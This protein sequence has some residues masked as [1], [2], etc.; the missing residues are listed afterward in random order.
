MYKKV[1]N[2][3]A[4]LMV[5]AMAISLCA[6]A[7][8]VEENSV[9]SEQNILETVD[10]NH[11][12]IRTFEREPSSP[13]INSIGNTMT[14]NDILLAL[15]MEQDF[16]DKLSDEDLE[17]YATSP[18]MVATISYAKIDAENNVTYV[19][20]SEA[21]QEA[22]AMREAQKDKIEELKIGVLPGQEMKTNAQDTYEDSYMRV[23]YLVT[24]M[25]NGLY[26]FSTDAR[27]LTMPFFRSKDSLG[28]CAQNCTVDYATRSGW[29]EYDITEVNAGSVTYDYYW[30]SIDED[31]FK[32]AIN[33]SWY[34]SAGILN[35]PNDGYSETY[36]IMFDDFKAHYE[37]KGYVNYTELESYFNTSGTYDHATVAISFSPSVSIGIDG[38]SAS[39]G[40][41][42]FGATDTRTVDLLIHYVP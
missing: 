18:K 42:I 22:E 1:K 19:T 21:I 13:S 16:I 39:I 33:G 41:N 6:S 24:D 11:R 30:D 9:M 23:F 37:Y 17:I 10:S 26:F 32:N 36:S 40:L 34:G 7:Y 38:P 12:I 5:I 28:A 3:L 35:L 4:C 14:T 2:V 8:A 31:D 29:Y 20:E 15:G 27:W 25:G